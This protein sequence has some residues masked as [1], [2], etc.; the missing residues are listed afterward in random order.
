MD[1]FARDNLPPREQW[2][3]LLI[4]PE[5]DYPPQLNAAAELLSGPWADRPCVLGADETWT[6]A[7]LRARAER[8]ARVLVED[9]GLV[10]GNRVLLHGYNDPQLVACWFG[11]LLAGGVVVATMPMLRAGELAKVIGRAQV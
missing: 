1:T 10:P 8:I 4:T 6:Y 11:I 7:E 9:M 3:E 5:L 2:P